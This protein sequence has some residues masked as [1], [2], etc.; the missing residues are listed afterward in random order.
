LVGSGRA[1][2]SPLHDVH[3]YGTTTTVVPELIEFGSLAITIT[4]SA[5]E[6]EDLWEPAY[7]AELEST[8]DLLFNQ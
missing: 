8:L 4:D 3:V 6:G 7:T 2:I 1:D 5:A